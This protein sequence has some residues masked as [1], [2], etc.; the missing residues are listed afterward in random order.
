MKDVYYT[1]TD[2]RYLR[3]TCTSQT[4][5]YEITNILYNTLHVTTNGAI[6]FPNAAAKNEKRKLGRHKGN[7]IYL[8]MMMRK[9]DFAAA[10][11]LCDLACHRL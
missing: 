11:M 8:F 6:I 2:A 10:A 4:K 5:L 7:P 9:G 3:S 1:S